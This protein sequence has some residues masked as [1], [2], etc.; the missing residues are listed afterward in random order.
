MGRPACAVIPQVLNGGN[1][2]LSL[3]CCGARAYLDALSE[4]VALWALPASKLEQYCQQIAVLAGANETL[5]KFHRGRR[6]DVASGKRPTVR[7]SL[8][9]FSLPHK[10]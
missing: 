10:I 9:R 1:A 2:A 7:E 5:K 4:S 3:G 8:E 6:E